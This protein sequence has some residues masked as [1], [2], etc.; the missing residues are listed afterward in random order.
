MVCCALVQ[1][2]HNVVSQLAIAREIGSQPNRASG[3]IDLGPADI[4]SVVMV[5]VRLGMGVVS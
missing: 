3:F 5:L 2:A 4:P 1:D